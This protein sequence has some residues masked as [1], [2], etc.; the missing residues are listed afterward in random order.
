MRNR[1]AKI[2]DE[3]TVVSI[4]GIKIKRPFRTVIT[5][6]SHSINEMNDVITKTRFKIAKKRSYAQIAKK[7]NS[8]YVK[9]H[10]NAE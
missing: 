10:D 8:A 5:T 6:K 9:M 3:N 7:I 1:F 4:A 2:K